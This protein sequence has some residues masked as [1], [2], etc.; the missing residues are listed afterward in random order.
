MNFLEVVQDL[1]S[2]I[3]QRN[4]IARWQLVSW[5]SD[6]IDILSVS[7]G[8]GNAEISSERLKVGDERSVSALCPLGLPTPCA[9]MVTSFD[10]ELIVSETLPIRTK[11]P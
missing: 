9:H 10:A 4:R 11:L 1:A 5:P 6:A 2:A 7:G 3:D 8:Y